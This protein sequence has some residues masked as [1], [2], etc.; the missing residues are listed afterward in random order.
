MARTWA[1]GY[2]TRKGLKI[3]ADD[4]T[5]I[6]VTAVPH[7]TAHFPDPESFEKDFLS[8]ISPDDV[9]LTPSG[10]NFGY[11]RACAQRC[12][13]RWI[14]PGTLTAVTGKNRNDKN[15]KN[16]APDLLK[17]NIDRPELF[18]GYQDTDDGITALRDK[19]MEWM[20]LE[21]QI[22][23]VG[24]ALSQ[25]LKAEREHFQYFPEDRETWLKAF[26]SRE[27]RI[28]KALFRKRV[29]VEMTDG[30]E[31]SAK[32]TIRKTG[33]RRYDSF[34]AGSESDKDAKKDLQD[35]QKRIIAERLGWFP[36]ENVLKEVESE[37]KKILQSLPENSLFDGLLSDGTIRTR[38]FVLAMMRN[39]L[40]YP[41]ARAMLAYEGINAIN[42]GQVVDRAHGETAI[43]HPRGRQ[44]FC[45]DFPEKY[46][47][48]DT[49]G[50][51]RALYYA[52]K[53][54]QYL[55]YWDL[56]ELT[57]DVF[58]ALGRK[59]K[60]EDDDSDEVEEEMVEDVKGVDEIPALLDRLQAL[61]DRGLPILAEN[62][63]LPKW[64]AELK[65]NPDPK[66]L[67]WLFA[68]G[69][70]SIGIPGAS[71][72]VR[73]LNLQMTPKRIERQTKRMLGIVLA[74]AVYYRWREQIGIP[75]PLAEDHI[76][77]GQWQY[78]TGRR[79]AVPERYDH[80]VTLQYYRKKAEELRARQTSAF[81][82]SVLF[83]LMFP[84]ER[85]AFLQTLSETDRV[86]VLEGLT[87]KER[88][89]VEAALVN[90]GSVEEL[91]EV[92][93]VA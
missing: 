41:N 1:I 83:K 29:G 45:F 43:G 87:D 52:Y 62:K 38:A 60:D 48:N 24:N 92:E 76:F 74:N 11:L 13:V 39:P 53:Q 66:R 75:A 89:K 78:V 22:T 65:K 81:P 68:R 23:A 59:T 31:V 47:Q 63:E 93:S 5:T 28:A 33:E 80:T 82:N 42:N 40:R 20:R 19:A 21:Q 3:V 30:Q 26:V 77:T 2:A 54:H 79:D 55:V 69:Y 70:Q 35:E 50:F 56:I 32:A 16:V 17:L 61:F 10:P 27:L 90:G 9:V 84:E 34:F 8:Q 88:E 51:F 12:G 86:E 25:N 91:A 14:N 4:K 72:K 67:W 46:W 15:G 85:V 73:G 58:K 44:L 7:G 18:Y 6:T 57:R 71:G 36:L 64:I 37:T 49:I